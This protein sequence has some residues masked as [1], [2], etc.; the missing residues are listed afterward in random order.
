MDFNGSEEKKKEDLCTNEVFIRF[1]KTN[2]FFTFVYF[3]YI[4]LS[5][6]ISNF[7][8]FFFQIKVT[9][10][11]PSARFVSAK[12]EIKWSLDIRKWHR[13]HQSCEFWSFSWVLPD[14]WTPALDSWSWFLLQLQLR[15]VD[16]CTQNSAVGTPCPRAHPKQDQGLSFMGKHILMSSNI[17]HWMFTDEGVLKFCPGKYLKCFGLFQGLFCPV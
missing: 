6:K 4:C 14:A 11:E 3:Q 12:S 5:F 13:S 2:F 9:E 16:F 8:P 17:S 7:F 15:L 10:K 1:W